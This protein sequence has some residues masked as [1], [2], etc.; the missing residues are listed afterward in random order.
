MKRTIPLIIAALSGTILIVSYF[1]PAIE[2][3][4]EVVTAWFNILAAVAFILGG[5][6]LFKV[7]LKAISDREAGWGYSA[8]ILISFVVSLLLGIFKVGVSPDWDAEYP[9]EVWTEVAAADLPGDPPAAGDDGTIPISANLRYRPEFGV[10]AATGPLSDEERRA[11]TASSP[12]GY[13]QAV[14]RLDAMASK[15]TT[16]GPVSVT[17]PMSPDRRDELLAG[18]PGVDVAYGPPD[19]PIVEQLSALGPLSDAQRL[20][21]ENFDWGD[22]AAEDPVARGE[23]GLDLA[24]SL[25]KAGPLTDAQRELL[26][27]PARRLRLVRNQVR[28][29]YVQSQQVKFGWTNRYLA[30]GSAFW[31][32]YQY[33]FQPLTATVFAMLAFYLSS[34]AFRAFRAKNLEAGLLLGTALLV[35]IGVTPAGTWLSGLIAEDSWASYLRVDRLVELIMSVFV[36]AGNRAI[37]IGIALGIAATSLKVILGIDRSY[38]GKD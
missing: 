19:T 21:A 17:G 38:L 2:G 29:A 27:V 6:S 18:P 23:L 30:E 31:W 28:A 16:V 9:G 11:M 1:V 14:A 7:Q 15:V 8:I 26:L 3:L 24:F 33:L 13:P 4:G 12:G 37:Y 5:A 20:L 10:L 25:L 35:L 22:P 32:C 36:T 34:A